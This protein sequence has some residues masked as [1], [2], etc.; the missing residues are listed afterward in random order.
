MDVTNV[1][2][3]KLDNPFEKWGHDMNEFQTRG[4]AQIDSLTQ[5]INHMGG[6]LI[7]GSPTKWWCPKLDATHLKKWGWS[8][9]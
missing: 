5:I 6:F 7:R 9:G 1:K 2:G 4:S 3:P 8:Y